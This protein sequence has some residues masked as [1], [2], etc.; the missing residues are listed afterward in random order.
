[1]QNVGTYGQEFGMLLASWS[2]SDPRV[3]ASKKRKPAGV[4]WHS[5]RAQGGANFRGSD[6]KYEYYYKG[7]TP[8][9]NEIRTRRE[10]SYLKV[11]RS[12]MTTKGITEMSFPIQVSVTSSGHKRPQAI[13][14]Q[15][16]VCSHK[17]VL[18]CFWRVDSL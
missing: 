7:L 15:A 16:G 1:M 2:Y 5:P 8:G 3:R 14:N 6:K 13:A 18:A 17:L 10:T 12:R 4:S 11:S 9:A